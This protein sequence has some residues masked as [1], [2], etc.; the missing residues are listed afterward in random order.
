MYGS[1]MFTANALLLLL[2][3]FIFTIA[4]LSISYLIGNI[5]KSRG[6]MSAAVNVVA[7]GSCFISGV[8]VPQ[9]LLG[10]TVLMISSFT[11]TY[12]YVKANN[13]IVNI[14]RFNTENLMPVFNSMLIVLG[15]AVAILTVTL[16]VI[17][18]KR[19]SY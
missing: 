2:N 3:S 17:K 19:M 7:L 18:Q 8:F 1:Y 9:A 12:W 6:A 10:K 15:F 11:P 13:D 4:A 5:I 16:V 14:V